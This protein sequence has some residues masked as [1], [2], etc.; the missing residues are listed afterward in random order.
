MQNTAGGRE[1]T[2]AEEAPARGSLYISLILLHICW[3]PN[4][5]M[6]LL[7]LHVRLRER[8]LGLL[9]SWIIH[10]T[11]RRHRAVDNQH[12]QV[13]VERLKIFRTHLVMDNAEPLPLVL[14]RRTLLID[15]RRTLFRT[16]L[17]IVIGRLHLV[18]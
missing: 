4:D 13:V 1:T 2:R 14:E 18:L 5:I 15:N 7:V 16:H 11:R 12:L 8:I 10:I 17:V 3:W 9:L 6:V